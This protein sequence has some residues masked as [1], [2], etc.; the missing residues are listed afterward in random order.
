MY[1]V[2]F[3]RFDEP[4]ADV[5]WSHV[6]SHLSRARVVRD[7]DG[8]H[9]AHRQCA[10]LSRTSFFFV[11]DADNEI[12]HPSVFDDV[13]KFKVSQWD[14]NY[15]HIWNAKNPVN[16][17]IY[18]WGGIKLVPKKLILGMDKNSLD[19]TTSFPLKVIQE[20]AVA[21][22]T[23]FNY[24]PLET[25]RSAF[26]ECVKLTIS[27]DPDAASRLEVWRSSA[28]GPYAAE[29]LRGANEGHAYA[30]AHRDDPEALRNINSYAW[31]RERF[32]A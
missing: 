1:D 3:L 31:L 13:F 22:I 2:F 21:S 5:H 8:I 10:S 18:G 29:C 30:L 24:G 9:A 11:I 16:G 26:R 6:Y 12:A 14:V 15:V 20:P 17:L 27:H 7:I 19:M 25:W 28:S 32:S 23:H 4:M